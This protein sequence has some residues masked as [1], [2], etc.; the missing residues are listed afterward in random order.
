MRRFSLSNPT[1]LRATFHHT[2]QGL[3]RR[4][5]LAKV[6][7]ASL[8]SVPAATLCVSQ[9]AHAAKITVAITG[10]VSSG[11]DTTGVFVG[12]GANLAGYPFS[13]VY[14]FDSTK[15]QSCGAVYSCIENAG[16]DDNP[17]TKAVITINGNEFTYGKLEAIYPES[18]GLR[19]I[20]FAGY[21]VY[22]SFYDLEQYTG[23][24]YTWGGSNVRLDVDIKKYPCTVSA[25]W[26]GP[27]NYKLGPKDLYPSYDSFTLYHFFTNTDGQQYGRQE[28]SGTLAPEAIK[29]SVEHAG[30]ACGE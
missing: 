10:T 6:A 4:A 16:D 17:I 25:S 12:A 28:A 5:R 3:I 23:L 18:W 27:L 1:A 30:P 20:N 8:M 11:T 24:P 13:L 14:I 7:I 15:G 26:D 9:P 21:Q 2:S 19:R 22:L 29:I